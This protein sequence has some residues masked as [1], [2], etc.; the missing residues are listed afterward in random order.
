VERFV[1]P[2]VEVDGGGAFVEVP[3]EVVAALG[4]GG[5]IK[6][7]ARF[8]G[9]DY[10]GSVVTMGGAKVL[11]VLKAIRK[12]LAKAPGDQLTVELERDDEERRVDVPDDLASALQQA[13]EREAFDRLSFSHRREYVAWIAEAKKSETRARRIAQ[14]VERFRDA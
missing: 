12:Q 14:T 9:V 3:P 4:G 2:L 13:G 7:R 6:V 8:D 11:G 1:A 10:R 5:R